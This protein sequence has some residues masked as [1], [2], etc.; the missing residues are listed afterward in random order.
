MKRKLIHI[1]VMFVLLIVA[2]TGICCVANRMY[3][4]QDAK[5]E[6]V[7]CAN[8]AEQ[9]FLSGDT[10]AATEAMKQLKNNIWDMSM[11]THNTYYLI[12]IGG[13]SVLFVLIIFGYIY[14]AIFKPFENMKKYTQEIAK[15]NFDLPLKY[16]R[17]NY[18]GEFT[19]AFDSMRSEIIKARS[20][21][22]EAIENNKTVIATLS[23]D[24]KTPIASIR[25]YA[26]G[27]EA[28][29]DTTPEKRAKYLSDS[30]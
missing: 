24:I 6:T 29:M 30:D 3:K 27:L 11:Q 10:V 7:V 15:G 5:A 14:F 1:T 16:E 20:C 18:F 12:L 26:E 25:A 21:E 13:V 17:S 28:N 22:K 23:H 9:L 4:L 2:I 8:E 19:W